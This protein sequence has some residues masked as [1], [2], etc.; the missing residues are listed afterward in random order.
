MKYS[1]LLALLLA[2]VGMFA[3]EGTEDAKTYH[4]IDEIAYTSQQPSNGMKQPYKARPSRSGGQENQG[5]QH[6]AQNGQEDQRFG[7]HVFGDYL[8]W[9]PYLSNTP[10]ILLTNNEQNLPVPADG[11]QQQ[12]YTNLPFTFSGAS[13]FRLGLGNRMEWHKLGF[14][15]E[16]T[17]FHTTSQETTSNN[18][19]EDGL[20]NNNSNPKAITGIWAATRSV[21]DGVAFYARANGTLKLDQI[22]FLFSTMHNPVSWFQ[23]TPGAGIRVFLSSFNL[24]V[25]I[26]KNRWGTTNVVS[27]PPYNTEFED[28]IQDFDSVGALFSMKSMF[29]IGWGVSSFADFALGLVA[30]NLKNTS[31]SQRVELG[32]STFDTMIENKTT[33][34]TILD[35]DLGL[36]YEWIN[37]A[38]NWGFFLQAAY[39]VHYMPNFLQP[40]LLRNTAFTRVI[41][42]RSDLTFQG[43]RAR[44]GVTF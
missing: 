43:L 5:Y 1:T 34:K 23:V 15:V 41:D 11:V 12:T 19:L 22:D 4:E 14:D 28:V 6:T 31:N 29:D 38:K 20:A 26:E 8:Y 32:A 17:R 24:D 2:P 30:G 37:D 36:Q 39:E 35:F 9:K 33:I 13:G 16:W 27:E 18:A 21:A 7:F 25:M 44:A 40:L 10:W 3:S 42:Y